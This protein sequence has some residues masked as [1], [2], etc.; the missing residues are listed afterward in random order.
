MKSYELLHL[1]GA[2]VCSQLFNEFALIDIFNVRMVLMLLFIKL[3]ELCMQSILLIPKDSL[4]KVVNSTSLK[5]KKKFM[6]SSKS[7]LHEEGLSGPWKT[8]QLLLCNIF[9]KTIEN[10]K[11]NM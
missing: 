10:Q 5:T 6:H 3:F 7:K 1:D 2:L 11:R 8:W 4:E 9:C